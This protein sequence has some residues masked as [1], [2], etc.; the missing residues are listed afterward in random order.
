MCLQINLANSCN[1]I[2][3][4]CLDVAKGLGVYRVEVVGVGR[5]YVLGMGTWSK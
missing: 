4:S 5:L 1:K 3:A 2:A